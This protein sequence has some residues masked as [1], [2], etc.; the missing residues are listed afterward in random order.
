MKKSQRRVVGVG[1]GLVA[2]SA[3]A[4]ASY[5]FYGSKN[6]EKHRK[7]IVHL[8]DELKTEWDLMQR[9]AGRTVEKTVAN[10][11]QSAKKALVKGEKKISKLLDK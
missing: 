10:T 5:Y 1:A 6:A 7:E 8:M 2:A 4:A 11:R 9:D 3:T